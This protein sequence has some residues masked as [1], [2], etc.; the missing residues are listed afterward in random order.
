MKENKVTK[1]QIKEFLK[2]NRGKIL[3]G[4]GL[5]VGAVLGY[6]YGKDHNVWRR[7]DTDGLWSFKV[8][9]NTDLEICIYDA[10]TDKTRAYLFKGHKAKE[11]IDK[12]MDE[13]YP[14]D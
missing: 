1:D 4:V 9:N 6:I 3:L 5:T 10:V 8:I 11:I 7:L 13:Y 12:L 2:N 14:G